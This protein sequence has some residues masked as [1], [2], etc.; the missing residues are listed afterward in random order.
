[1]IRS[2]TLAPKSIVERGGIACV[3]LSLSIAACTDGAR[4]GP[5][6]TAAASASSLT[7][8]RQAPPPPSD[9]RGS[10]VSVVGDRA[11][12]L[13]TGPRVDA[14]KGDWMIRGGG[15]VA[16][17][18]ADDGYVVDYG[19]EGQADALV[20]VDSVVRVGM[21][22]SDADVVAIEGIDGAV[23]VEKRVHDRP[24]ALHTWTWLEGPLLRIDSVMVSTSDKPILAM[25]LGEVYRW[26]NVPTW[27]EGQGF[28]DRGGSFGTEF[29]GRESQGVAYAARSLD[30]R[31][32]AR[33]S[34]QG[35]A[36]FWAAANTGEVP[37]TLAPGETSPPRRIVV[38]YSNRSLGDAASRLPDPARRPTPQKVAIPDRPERGAAV[39][40]AHCDPPIQS[41]AKIE[42]P[43]DPADKDKND[44]DK[45][46]K[47][48]AP[49]DMPVEHAPFSRFFVSEK[50]VP[51]PDGCFVARVV[52]PGCAPGAWTKPTDLATSKTALPT[53]GTLSWAIT[54]K[55]AP[56]PA[57]LVVKGLEDTDDPDWGDDPDAGAAVNGI[58]T[59]EGSG[60]RLIP[61]GHYHV[62]VGR[63]PE[64]TQH[65]EDITVT[66][67]KV[68]DIKAEL[69][70]VVDTTGWISAD[71]HVHAIPSFDAP[72]PLVERMRSLAGVGVEVGVA[73]DHNRIT[74]YGPAISDAGL[75]GK[76]ASVVGDEI[77][78]VGTEFGHF[79]AFP[80][81]TNVEPPATRDVAPKDLFAEMRAAGVS[82]GAIVLQVNHPRMSDIGYFD[83]L[84]LDP[85]D[86]DGSIARSPLIDMDFDALEV[87]NGDHYADIPRV[88]KVMIDWYALLRAG[89]RVTATGNSD[90]HKVTYQDAGEP[91]NWVRMP[92]DD[93]AHFDERAFVDSIR[94][95]RVIVSNGP[96]I[97]LKVGDK[98]IGDTISGGDV[99]VTIEVQA[100]PWMDVS[101]V[102]LLNRGHLVRVFEGPFDAEVKR[103][104]KTFSMK[105]E[106][107]DFLVATVRGEKSMK[108]LLRRGATPFGFTNPIFVD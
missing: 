46:P 107:G 60:S 4:N 1:M 54:E 76:M 57:K 91:R 36:G 8:K 55:G 41:L 23:H 39:E 108:W 31:M 87:F 90:S 21:D 56:V 99:D 80:L 34:S 33:F 15:F 40:I 53:S 95:G 77:T 27:V 61:P 72:V 18:S 67:D 32:L 71:L 65:E 64:Y 92:D 35:L 88:E 28:M 81:R 38:S 17:V 51:I 74:D 9:V 75:K 63:G 20:Y 83:L 69:E 52:A 2:K 10:A 84:R 7:A 85:T 30:G 82:P 66:A 6:S 50:E 47:K 78:S 16:V 100:P 89:H 42:P 11:D 94:G 13:L 3:A 24:L 49:S 43:P 29:V 19:R 14:K 26:G 102:E 48:I 98:G 58:Y 62:Y 59:A 44:K 86:V 45:K 93:P 96:F 70:R 104:T 103:F 101:R 25:T 22:E 37:I 5:A 105:V 79:N 106:K 68:I 12:V 73:T 97:N